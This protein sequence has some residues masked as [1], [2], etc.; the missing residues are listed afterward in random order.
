MFKYRVENLLDAFDRGDVNVVAHQANCFNAMGAGIAKQIAIRYPIAKEVDDKTERGDMNKLGNISIAS[1]GDKAIFNLYGQYM[2]GQET[3]YAAQRLC[4]YKMQVKMGPYLKHV[5]LG[6][7]QIGC[8]LGGGNWPLVYSIIME[9]L[10]HTNT[11]IYVL[12]EKFVP[13][14]HKHLIEDSSNAN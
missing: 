5:K 8:G 14:D 12:D 2:P 9:E 1:L 6:I 13:A 7:P 10:V 4:L 11:T 3:K